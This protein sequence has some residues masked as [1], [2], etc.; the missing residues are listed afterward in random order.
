MVACRAVLRCAV[1]CCAG[2]RYL[3]S[4]ESMGTAK[5]ECVAGCACAESR[6]DG[7]WERRA[8]IMQMHEFQVGLGAEF[9]GGAG[10]GAPPSL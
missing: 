10:A 4:Y 1:L 3:R 7:T 6:V 9:Q 8:T 2:C 5:V